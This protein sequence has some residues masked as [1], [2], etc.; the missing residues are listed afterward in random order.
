MKNRILPGK[1]LGRKMVKQQLL[2]AAAVAGC[3]LSSPN[4]LCAMCH[5]HWRLSWVA[6]MQQ[7]IS[8]LVCD[9]SRAQACAGIMDPE[10]STGHEN[11]PSV[12]RSNPAWSRGACGGGGQ[13]G[14]S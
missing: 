11:A 1:K 3:Y 4:L 9:C 13:A 7:S 14:L 12:N 8:V 2:L 6:E 10:P 5:P